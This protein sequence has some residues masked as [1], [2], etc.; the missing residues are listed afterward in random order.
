MVNIQT[1][2]WH[3]ISPFGMLLEQ[4]K[5]MLAM[6]HVFYT[7]AQKHQERPSENGKKGEQDRDRI[8]DMESFLFF[9]YK[10]ILIRVCNRI[11]TLFGYGIPCIK[12]DNEC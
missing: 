7:N 12:Q 1:Y 8:T 6:P 10:Y 9:F 5:P 2:K 3:K 11:K 4:L